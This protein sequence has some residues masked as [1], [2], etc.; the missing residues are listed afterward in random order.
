MADSRQYKQGLATL[1]FPDNG[2]SVR[3]R[4]NPDQ[5]DWSFK[6]KTAVIDTIGGRVVQVLGADLSDMVVRGRFGNRQEK[7]A[8][9]KDAEAFLAQMRKIANYQANDATHSGSV[10]HQPAVFSFPAKDWSFDVYLKGITD[11]QGGIAIQ[12]TSGKF[13]YDYILTF[14]IFNDRN[15]TS[16]IIGKNNG[17]LVKSGDLAIEQYIN[18]IFDGIG[19]K[20]S[21][22]NGPSATTDFAKD[23][24]FGGAG[25]KKS[26]SG[27][28]GSGGPGHMQAPITKSPG[29]GGS[30]SGPTPT[31]P[32]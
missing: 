32:Q 18:R 14:S 21:D 19:W 28:T 5:V 8:Y 15:N 26:K 30:L 9:W 12:H 25:T 2:P 3:F 7:D 11:G 13:S 31:L 27:S 17:N 20:V 22:Y 6:V 10:M 16:R 24:L 1:S 4:I 29:S 23:A